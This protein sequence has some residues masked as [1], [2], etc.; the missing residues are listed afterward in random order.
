MCGA[1]CQNGRDGHQRQDENGQKSALDHAHKI[2]CAPAAVKARARQS[3]QRNSQFC[4]NQCLREPMPKSAAADHPW[5]SLQDQPPPCRQT[6]WPENTRRQT[7]PGVQ[8]GKSALAGLELTLRL[9]DH[10]N[11]PFAT[12]QTVVAMARA[13]GLE[14]V[15]Y[16]HD[17]IIRF[18]VPRRA[19]QTPTLHRSFPYQGRRC[20]AN[21][22]TGYKDGRKLLAPAPFCQSPSAPQQTPRSGQGHRWHTAST[23]EK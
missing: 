23:I 19:T 20:G 10:V 5:F 2:S 11:A 12:H 14:R 1:T 4:E 9:V 6:C 21:A 7:H 3:S 17:C 13:Q 18:L 22:T 15:S 8:P 16:F